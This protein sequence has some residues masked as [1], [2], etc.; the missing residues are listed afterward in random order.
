VQCT[1]NLPQEKNKLD[2][3]KEKEFVKFDLRKSSGRSGKE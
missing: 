1:A 3:N 2:L